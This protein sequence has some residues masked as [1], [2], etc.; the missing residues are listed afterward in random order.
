MS[1]DGSRGRQ[2]FASSTFL[3]YFHLGDLRR[4]SE[5]VVTQRVVEVTCCG[6]AARGVGKELSDRELGV[7]Y[8]MC[9]I[10]EW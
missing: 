9:C 7:T 5:F 6:R 1:G 4:D 2:S 3:S 8:K 10:M